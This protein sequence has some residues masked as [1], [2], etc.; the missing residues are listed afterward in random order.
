MTGKRIAWAVIAVAAC[1]A[2]VVF[3]LMRAHRLRTIT[4]AQSIPI[5][6]AVI[7]SFATYEEALAW[8]HSPAYTTAK[9]QRFKGAEY[10][11]FIVQGM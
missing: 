5:E 1:V 10:R 6:G 4:E 7:L 8:Y 2:I 3:L 11:V 9:E